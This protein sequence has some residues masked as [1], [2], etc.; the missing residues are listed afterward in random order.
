MW[1]TAQRTTAFVFHRVLADTQR[2]GC[3][4]KIAIIFTINNNVFFFKLF[5]NYLSLC[6]NN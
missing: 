4:V 2:G 5:F 1:T 6:L 3:V